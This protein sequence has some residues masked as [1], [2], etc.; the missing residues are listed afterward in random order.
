[1]N[2]IYEDTKQN[3]FASYPSDNIFACG[4]FSV[5]NVYVIRLL[6]QV[7]SCT[8]YI[9]AIYGNILWNTGRFQITIP[10]RYEKLSYKSSFLFSSYTIFSSYYC[11]VVY[12]ELD[13]VCSILY[14]CLNAFVSSHFRD[15]LVRDTGNSQ[16]NALFFLVANFYD[17]LNNKYEHS[18]FQYSIPCFSLHCLNRLNIFSLFFKCRKRLNAAPAFCF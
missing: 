1:M 13:A 7:L 16:C 2:C 9:S 11:M 18:N 4:S 14:I 17:I 15:I 8:Q 12:T 5:C 3:S 6:F 10:A